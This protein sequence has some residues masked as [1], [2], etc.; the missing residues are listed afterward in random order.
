MTS[1]YYK[2]DVSSRTDHKSRGAKKVR[3]SGFVPGVLYYAGE[4]SV[5]ISI[6]LLYTSDAADD[7]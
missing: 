4:E 2:L 1:S 5:N 7:L 6:C 3:K